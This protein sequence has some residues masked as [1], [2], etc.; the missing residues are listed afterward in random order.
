[1]KAVIIAAGRGERME[2]LTSHT[3][4]PLITLKRHSLI[5]YVISSCKKAGIN[6]FLIVTG[7]KG[8]LIQRK[9]GE[10]KDL[11]VNIKYVSNPQWQKGNATSLMAAREELQDD[12]NFILSMSDHIY[13]EAL[14]IKALNDYNGKPMVCVDRNPV[15]VKDLEDATK[16]MVKLDGSVKDIGKEIVDWNYIDTGVFILPSNVFKVLDETVSELSK[17]MMMFIEAKQLVA[18]DV[19]DIPWLDIDTLQDLEYARTVVPL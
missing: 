11:G 7:Y 5:E 19:T 14:I 18:C 17:H 8:E 4:K 6:D 13:N 1:M 9:L 15:H 10:G 2:D 3:P 16:V 12:K